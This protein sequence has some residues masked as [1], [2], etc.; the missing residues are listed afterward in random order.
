MITNKT[1]FLLTLFSGLLLSIGFYFLVS[2]GHSG[3]IIGALPSFL[4]VL[5]IDEIDFKNKGTAI[6]VGIIATVLIYPYAIYV[7]NIEGAGSDLTWFQG[8]I[9]T[10]IGL[11]LVI[12]SKIA[13]FLN[14]ISKRINIPN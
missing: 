13:H 5:G 6:I 12:W 2:P 4:I 8:M 14:K 11:V 1:T 9:S 7:G 10:S 3:F